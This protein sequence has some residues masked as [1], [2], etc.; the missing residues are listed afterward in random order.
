MAHGAD[1]VVQSLYSPTQP[2][3][4]YVPSDLSLLFAPAYT[5]GARIHNNSWGSPGSRYDTW[6]QTAAQFVWDHPD[7]II[8]VA[9]GNS[10]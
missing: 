2:Y 8:V 7:M 9:A 1:L 10:G 3:D 6:A 5:D 4:L